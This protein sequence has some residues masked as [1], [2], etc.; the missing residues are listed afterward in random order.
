MVFDTI[1]A[2]FE[3]SNELLDYAT[4]CTWC[5]TYLE[6][7]LEGLTKINKFKQKIAP[8][9][10]VEDKQVDMFRREPNTLIQNSMGAH[11]RPAPKEQQADPLDRH[12]RIK[13]LLAR[14]PDLK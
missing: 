1:K 12:E 7:Q 8:D 4:A 6:Q 5:E 13:R 3:E 9:T 14:N 11:S 10:K 2:Y